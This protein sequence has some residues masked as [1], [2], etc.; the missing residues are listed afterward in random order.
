MSAA[1]LRSGATGP[2]FP[3][4]TNNI[5]ARTKQLGNC[6][7][8]SARTGYECYPLLIV[9]NWKARVRT[10]L[11]HFNL[12]QERMLHPWDIALISQATTILYFMY[13][14]PLFV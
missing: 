4:K 2:M 14:L 10:V 1:S 9:V 7:F 8:R 5:T 12:E 3:L 13:G 11:T 6:I